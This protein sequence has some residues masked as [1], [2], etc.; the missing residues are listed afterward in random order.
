MPIFTFEFRS[1]F[2]GTKVKYRFQC[3]LLTSSDS[4]TMIAGFHNHIFRHLWA[5]HERISRTWCFQLQSPSKL[6]ALHPSP[7]RSSWVFRSPNHLSGAFSFWPFLSVVWFSKAAHEFEAKTQ[8]FF[9]AVSNPRIVV[10]ILLGQRLVQWWH[11]ANA[12]KKAFCR[13]KSCENSTLFIQSATVP[14]S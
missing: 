12:T 8:R 10:H 7:R 1:S 5:Y 11:R 9:L 2:T 14:T 3:K 6:R 13:L 4:C